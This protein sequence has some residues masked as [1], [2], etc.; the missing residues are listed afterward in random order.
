M[1]TILQQLTFFL[2]ISLVFASCQKQQTFKITGSISGIPDGTIID[3]YEVEFD[4]AE[5]I[6]SDT[7]KNGKF[8]FV[9]RTLLEPVEMNLMVRDSELYTGSCR[10]WVENTTINI[11]SI[12]QNG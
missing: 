10:I 1:K 7:I 4:I 3:L 5:R 12:P 9:G 6:Q 11:E 8:V 2:L